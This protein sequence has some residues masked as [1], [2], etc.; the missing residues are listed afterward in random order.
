[1]APQPRYG[2]AAAQCTL[3]ASGVYKGSLGHIC[4]EAALA[5]LPGSEQ[6]NFLAAL[7]SGAN[8]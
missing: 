6:Q 8:G 2:A 7:L 1:M 3:A 5:T 4:S